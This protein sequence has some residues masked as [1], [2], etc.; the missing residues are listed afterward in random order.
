VERSLTQGAVVRPEIDAPAPARTL[1]KTWG[2]EQNVIAP[3]LLKRDAHPISEAPTSEAVE[4]DI[5][6]F[7]P[8]LVEWSQQ[9]KALDE[10]VVVTACEPIQPSPAQP[11]TP[12]FTVA[13]QFTAAVAISST[14]APTYWEPRDASAPAAQW[15]AALEPSRLGRCVL[16]DPH[17]EIASHANPVPAIATEFAGW[18]ARAGG[19]QPAMT[20][21]AALAGTLVPAKLPELSGFTTE[22]AIPIRILGQE[23]SIV[24]RG[25]DTQSEIRSNRKPLYPAPV[26][27]VSPPKARATGPALSLIRASVLPVVFPGLVWGPAWN[28]DPLPALVPL[29]EILLSRAGDLDSADLAIP[30][31]VA[32]RQEPVDSSGVSRVASERQFELDRFPVL[33]APHGTAVDPWLIPAEHPVHSF[34]IQDESATT[35]SLPPWL[36]SKRTWGASVLARPALP[37][38]L[39][40]DLGWTGSQPALA[41]PPFSAVPAAGSFQTPHPPRYEETRGLRRLPK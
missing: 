35:P 41:D 14:A 34:H 26:S 21:L 36:W 11:H 18:T 27:L 2:P 9:Q 20:H 28:L 23:F 8:P 17:T 3:H 30:G 32:F 5:P 4:S 12:S 6:P 33:P 37:G 22:T 7:A 19:S 13:G 10:R 1:P 38:S 40:E 24:V 25:R 39:T 16:P 15:T 29:S 31:A